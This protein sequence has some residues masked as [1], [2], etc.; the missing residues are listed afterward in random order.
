MEKKDYDLVVKKHLPK[1]HRVYNALIAFLVGG[2][3]GVI[4]N[5]LVDF[6]S[7]ILNISSND[8]SVFMITTLI[9]VA[10]LL[11]ALGVFDNFVKFG[12]MGFIIPITGFAHSVCSA[13][14]D[15]KKEGL[16]YG[17]GSNIFKLAGSVIL[18]GVLSAYIFG[19]IRFLI[20]LV[21]GG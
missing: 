3:I 4:G 14:M 8:A 20:T 5:L 10:C 6:Y 9:F 13:A 17:I 15:Y 11:T 16:I 12:K 18:Y 19:I 7:Y 1:E 21:V 2:A